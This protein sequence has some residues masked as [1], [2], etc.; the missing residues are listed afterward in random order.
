MAVVYPRALTSNEASLEFLKQRVVEEH[1]DFSTQSATSFAN[2]HSFSDW[3]ELKQFVERSATLLD[4]HT[5]QFK[6]KLKADVAL[7][8]TYMADPEKLS[9]WAIPVTFEPRLG[10]AFQFLP[11]EWCGTI[12]VYVEGR[13]I[14]FDAKRGG[15]TSLSVSAAHDHSIFTLRDYLPPDFELPEANTTGPDAHLFDQPGGQGTHWHGVLAGWHTGLEDLRS[16]FG[17]K[18]QSFNYEG[19]DKLY[20]LLIRSYHRV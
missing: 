20:D 14:R 17:V 13:E 12:G 18:K 9:S 2:E 7:T 1:G 11:E 6:S 8:W 3:R 15:W 5:A 19:I 4:N 16:R 10:G